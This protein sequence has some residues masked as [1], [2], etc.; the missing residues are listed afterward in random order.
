[1]DITSLL[2]PLLCGSKNSK[3]GKEQQWGWCPQQRISC[4]SLCAAHLAFP[5]TSLCFV[6]TFF[7]PEAGGFLKWAADSA[8]FAREGNTSLL[9]ALWPCTL[10]SGICAG[11][12]SQV[13][14]EET[15][16][17]SLMQP[18]TCGFFGYSTQPS[19][20][21]S[22]FIGKPLVHVDKTINTLTAKVKLHMMQCLWECPG[23]DKPWG[24]IQLKGDLKHPISFGVPNSRET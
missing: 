20:N 22:E 15:E 7:N 12:W 8:Y 24:C 10:D 17:W 1:M 5:C 11:S 13:C 9:G 21:W 6:F 4:N 14:G 3:T 23:Y 19:T 16:K 2:T 18:T